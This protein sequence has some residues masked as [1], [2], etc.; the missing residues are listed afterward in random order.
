MTEEDN[1]NEAEKPDKE[2]EEPEK[3]KKKKKLKDTLVIKMFL[4]DPLATWLLDQA[5]PGKMSRMRHRFIDII[6]PVIIEMGKQRK[7]YVE[8]YA[9]K[10]KDGKVKKIFKDGKET[11]GLKIKPKNEEK[12]NKEWK[13]YMEEDF[14]I[15]ITKSNDDCIQ[16]VKGILLNTTYKFKDY[17]DKNGFSKPMASWYD[18]WCEAFEEALPD[19]K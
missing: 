11:D 17:V 18:Q 19:A 7:E 12:M 4:V 8:K 5:L 13:E 9:E 10:D 3:E 15:D 6:K 2:A 1:K 16:E 14:L